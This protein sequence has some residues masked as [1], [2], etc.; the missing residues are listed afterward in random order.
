MK[1]KYQRVMKKNKSTSK[2]LQLIVFIFILTSCSGN[3]IDI[4]QKQLI[5]TW[6]SVDKSD[7]LMFTSESDFYKSNKYLFRNHY[8]YKL[9]EDSIRIG[10]SGDMYIYVFPTMHK[11]TLNNN[12]L[13]IDFKSRQ[14]YG[15]VVEKIIYEKEK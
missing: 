2:I 8:N 3:E 14:C 15:F 12:N 5:G 10:Y 9:F 11:Y 4:N 6:I 1:T 13:T 7:T